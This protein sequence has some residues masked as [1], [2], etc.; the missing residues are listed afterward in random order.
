MSKGNIASYIDMEDLE[1]T[2][3]RI[4]LKNET[5]GTEFLNYEEIKILEFG[6][7]SLL[8]EMPPNQCGENHQLDLYIMRA[9]VKH[10]IKKFSDAKREKDSLQV[11]GKVKRITR[12]DNKKENWIVSIDLTQFDGYGW[13][14]IIE[15][16]IRKQ[17]EI[18]K[19]K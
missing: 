12:P 15:M 4:I 18:N 14:K 8:L 2:N 3:H 10:S 19:L 1:K 17:I 9:P 7:K 13:N 16:Y 11:I 6:L 5:S